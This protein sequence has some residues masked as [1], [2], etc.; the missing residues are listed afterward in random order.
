MTW[1][2]LPVP[3]EDRP[4]AFV[5]MDGCN[6]WLATQPLANA[7]LM[8]EMLAAQFEALNGWAISPRERFKIVETLRKP[9][10]AIETEAGKRYEGR[11]LPL[12]PVEQK[13][14]DASC[15][16]WRQLATG[17]LHCLRACLDKDDSLAEHHAK[18]VHRVLTSL[19]QEQLARYRAGAT[20]PA[21][22]WR[23]LHAAMASA[24]QLGVAAAQVGDRLFAETRESTPGGQYAMA[25]LLYLARPHE[26]SRSQFSAVQRW[27]ARWR[28]QAPLLA[29]PEAARDVRTLAID[30]TGDGPVHSGRG[31]PAHGRWLVLDAVLGK[32]KSRI[33]GLR[34]GQSPEEL[35]LGSGLPPDAC[36]GLLQFLHGALQSPPA[37]P[38]AA[39]GAAVDVRLAT[40]LD[41]IH[42]L[43]GGKPVNA[44]AAPTA[45][46]NRTMHEQIAIFGHVVRDAA[47][48][49]EEN[50][51]TWQLLLDQNGLLVL[52]RAPG[53]AGERL[54]NRCL[55]A[56]RVESDIR[57]AVFRSLE[58]QEDGGLLIWARVLPG[59]A[60]PLQATGRER[61]TNRIVLHPAVFLP[62]ASQTGGP[63]SLF[64]PAGA[65]ARLSRLDVA[66]LPE[67]LK[68]GAP[69][70]RGT[71]YERLACS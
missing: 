14:F 50:L 39:G 28:E 7:P 10:F 5:D 19:R 21:S 31:V 61:A 8:Q 45:Q 13:A 29:D 15:R 3:R 42:L 18:I 69:L 65:M 40:T 49:V 57:L 59:K 27:L 1:F 23:L 22:W 41:S 33:K 56:I 66:D 34:E 48:S 70:D 38:P 55:V 30:L 53:V 32:F 9:V 12:S 35:R 17:Y 46:S 52:R 47:P 24:E 37:P 51:E 11:P 60:T 62:A 58:V 44:P 16:L 68:V 36:I 4:P 25:L 20:I 2:S 71:N 6:A 43:L 54:G 64:V 67:G 63:A 26:L